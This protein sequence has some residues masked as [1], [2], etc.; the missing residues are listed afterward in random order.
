MEHFCKKQMFV[1]NPKIFKTTIA[2]TEN[3]Q[4]TSEMISKPKSPSNPG[5]R[6]RGW[7]SGVHTA[8]SQ[9]YSVV[10]TRRGLFFKP[11]GKNI[12]TFLNR[13]SRI[14]DLRGSITELQGTKT[15]TDVLKTWST[16]KSQAAQ[17]PTRLCG[18][19]VT[20]GKSRTS[21]GTA[22]WNTPKPSSLHALPPRP[23]CVEPGPR[24]LRTGGPHRSGARGP[25]TRRVRRLRR[26]G[27]HGAR[28]PQGAGAR[29]P[30]VRRGRPPDRAGPRL[31]LA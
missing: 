10:Q 22:V 29:C 25:G 20:S 7:G 28:A 3:L 5:R 15:E 16:I 11:G 21:V 31:P 2:K 18:Q 30:Q 19:A 17:V 8:T 6:T 24:L 9:L 14:L 4:K 12:P 26:R 23:G 27:E 1:S 13:R